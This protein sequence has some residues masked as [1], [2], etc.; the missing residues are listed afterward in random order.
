MRF[1]VSLF[2]LFVVG[3]TLG[4]STSN[5][6]QPASSE[7][8]GPSGGSMT[9]RGCLQ[10]NAG[11]YVL[12]EDKTSMVYALRGVGAKLDRQINHQVEV[13]GQL[14]PGSVKTGVRSEKSGSNPADTVRG[15]PGTV[16]QVADVSRDIR[17]IAKHCKAADAQ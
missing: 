16:L 12:I 9:V 13:T 10:R 2:L 8:A 5:A 14:E 15:A 7:G 6:Q 11:N 4:V 1:L 17:T 3:I